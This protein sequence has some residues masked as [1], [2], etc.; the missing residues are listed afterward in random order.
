MKFRPLLFFMALF[1][2]TKSRTIVPAVY[3]EATYSMQLTMN[4]AAPAFVIPTGAHVTS[5]IGMVHNKDTFLWKEN[6]LATAGLEDVAEVGNTTRMNTEID[7]ILARN[8][9]GSKF[10]LP[11]PA[12][13]GST[14]T[15]LQLNTYFS[16]VS[17]TSM[18]APSSDWFMGISKADLMENGHWRDSLV[19]EIKVYDAGT[20]EGNA[21]DYNN[22]ATSP[23]Q[24]VKQLLQSAL[25]NNISS[26][27]AIATVRFKKM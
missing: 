3:S 26:N 21:F 7:A 5:L 25:T 10:Q 1:S 14:T 17:L 19:M 11:A 27:A 20:E 13:N 9:A 2:C 4:W 22:P 24:P 15:V 12:I 16:N 8:K 23:Q 6:T 18:I